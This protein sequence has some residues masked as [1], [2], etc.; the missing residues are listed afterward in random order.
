MERVTCAIT[1]MARLA[2][3][4]A[5]APATASDVRNSRRDAPEVGMAQFVRPSLAPASTLARMPSLIG[6]HPPSVQNFRGIT[7]HHIIFQPTNT[8]PSPN[9]Q[10]PLSDQP[11]LTLNGRG[12]R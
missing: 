11:A 3:S 8:R 2:G 5:P 12:D 4:I 9:S 6:S 1:L 10:R 7:A